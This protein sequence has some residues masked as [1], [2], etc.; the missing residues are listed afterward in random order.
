M[1][2]IRSNIVLI[3]FE[4]VQPDSLELL[5][6]GH[7]RVLLFVGANQAK[8]P[9]EIVASMQKLGDRA[10]YVKIAGNGSNALDFHIAYYI[11]VLSATDPSAYFHI[12]SKDAG[13][14]PLIEHLRNKKFLVRRVNAISE[15]TIVKPVVEKP[16]VVKPTVV[17]PTVVKAAVVKA[18]V[19]KAA[20]VKAAVKKAA[21]KK[22]ANAKSPEERLRFVAAR[23]VHPKFTKPRTLKTLSSTIASFFQKQIS[24]KDVSAIVAGL[25]KR[26][27]VSVADTKLTYVA[28][29]DA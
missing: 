17:K 22:A 29:S 15:I 19:V 28:T 21:V 6:P 24:D 27:I 18:A 7:F 8:L 3:D 5:T 9:F 13:F 14:A 1:P 20:V 25:V 16:V 10:E 4:N 23:L 11:G 26:G 2:P 12:V